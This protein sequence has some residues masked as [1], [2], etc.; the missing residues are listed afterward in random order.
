MSGR[1]GA[2][3]LCNE[4]AAI[5]VQIFSFRQ[6]IPAELEL[7]P[8]MNEQ[9][10][11]TSKEELIDSGTATFCFIVCACSSSALYLGSSR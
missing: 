2:D 9:R 10:T 6:L 8:V 5:L 11:A 4:L 3:M 1:G 7:V